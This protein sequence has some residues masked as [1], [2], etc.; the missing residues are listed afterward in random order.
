MY[1]GGSI[2]TKPNAVIYERSIKITSCAGGKVKRMVLF[3]LGVLRQDD[4]DEGSLPQGSA[5]RRCRK[6]REI[7]G[8]PPDFGL[9]FSQLLPAA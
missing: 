1:N 4:E 3:E 9:N 8:C 7:S 6:N 5:N 2:N